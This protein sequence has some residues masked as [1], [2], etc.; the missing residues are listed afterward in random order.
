MTKRSDL[1]EVQRICAMKIGIRKRVR[2]GRNTVYSR[3]GGVT[4]AIQES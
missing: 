4:L 2:I 1:D 3:S